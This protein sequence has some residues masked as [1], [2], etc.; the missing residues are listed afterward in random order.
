MNV[1]PFKIIKK[2]CQEGSCRG[3]AAAG[4]VNS[5][6]DA[7]KKSRRRCGSQA[8]DRIS[9]PT[10]GGLRTGSR[11]ASGDLQTGQ[12]RRRSRSGASVKSNWSSTS[13]VRVVVVVVFV[14]KTIQ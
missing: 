14:E 3:R 5:V 11:A 6:C 8:G 12:V 1:A 7:S 2:K 13:T 4:S 9:V 10:V